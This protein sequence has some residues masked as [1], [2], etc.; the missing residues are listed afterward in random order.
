MNDD[1]ANNSGN[2]SNENTGRD[3]H[4]SRRGSDG[5]QA[6]DGADAKSKRGRLFA[7]R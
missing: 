6:D 2:R 7:S 4:K 1:I 3:R 5:D